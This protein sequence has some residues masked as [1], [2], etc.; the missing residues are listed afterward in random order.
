MS[1][2]ITALLLAAGNPC[3]GSTTRDVEQC[4][5][6]DLKRADTELN[7]YYAA[8]TK[9]LTEQQD[10]VALAKLR[11]AE[12]AWIAYRDA[13]CEAVYESWGQGT[14]R[15]AMNLGCRINLTKAR[16]AT[17]WRN[18]LTYSDSTPPILP[19]PAEA[20]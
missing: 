2:I 11:L 18:W 3:D 12:R 13:E 7:R 5:A 14:I 6:A 1:I 20:G 19:K 4:L 16:T 17:I 9:R 8:A 15:G 10:T